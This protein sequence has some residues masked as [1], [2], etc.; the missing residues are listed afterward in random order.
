MA[1]KYEAGEKS[2]DKKIDKKVEPGKKFSKEEEIA[3]H[4]GSLQALAAEYNELVKMLKTVEAI[5]KAHMERMEQLGFKFQKVEK[6]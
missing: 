5:I 2:L 4:Q 1:E 6:K 3:F